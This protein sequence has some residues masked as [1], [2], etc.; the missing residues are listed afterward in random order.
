[1]QLLKNG[2]SRKDQRELINAYLLSCINLAEQTKPGIESEGNIVD[3]P[4]ICD[5]DKERVNYVSNEFS[6]ICDY[7]NN[8]QK[9]PNR[10]DRFADYLQGLPTIFAV[11]YEGD[12]ILQIAEKWG[13]DVSTESKKDNVLKNWFNYISCK[14]WQLHTKL[15]KGA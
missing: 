7:P 11:D 6:E 10:Q 2:L 13:S 4:V 3:M 5:S 14:F 1:M 9:F 15:N 8:L 12:T